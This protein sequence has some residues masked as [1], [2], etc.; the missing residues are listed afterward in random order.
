ML[1]EKQS[2]KLINLKNI[3]NKHNS[4]F[5]IVINNIFNTKKK[6]TKILKNNFQKKI[7]LKNLENCKNK[8]HKIN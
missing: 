3:L 2:S 6:S 7:F 8:I 4:K 5:L 1:K